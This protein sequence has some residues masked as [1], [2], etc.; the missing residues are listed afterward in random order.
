MIFIISFSIYF[1]D[2]GETDP[3]NFVTAYDVG[4]ARNLEGEKEMTAHFERKKHFDNMEY[5][6]KSSQTK[7]KDGTLKVKSNVTCITDGTYLDLFQPEDGCDQ[8]YGKELHE[9]VKKFEAEETFVFIGADSTA[10]NTG[11][12]LYQG[13]TE[14]SLFCGRFR[15][16]WSVRC[17]LIQR[18]NR[19]GKKEPLF[20]AI[21]RVFFLNFRHFSVLCC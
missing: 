17:S 9:K 1:R 4:I 6:G 21:F 10:V 2:R 16:F 19:E 12:S 14:R 5:D 8:T 11:L 7:Q 13:P 18:G 15:Y 3:D 20:L